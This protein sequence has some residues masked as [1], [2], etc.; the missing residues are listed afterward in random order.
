MQKLKEKNRLLNF[1]KI[2]SAGRSEVEKLF[3]SADEKSLDLLREYYDKPNKRLRDM[4]GIT[5]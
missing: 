4:I 1:F 3:Y 2:T 5:F